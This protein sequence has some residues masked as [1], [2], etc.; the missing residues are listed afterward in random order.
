ML[1]IGIV[2]LRNAQQYIDALAE[3][4]AFSFKGIY[5]PC[6]LIDKNPKT[7][8]NVFQSFNDLCNQCNAV[9]FS[10]D[11]SLYHPLV[12]EAIRN[13]LDIFLSGVHNYNTSELQSLKLLHYEANT[14]I[15]VGHPFIY[16]TTFQEMKKACAQPLDIQCTITQ[17]NEQKIVSI[18][19][20]HVSS[21]LTL[22]NSSVHKASVNVYS[23]FSSMPDS[24][25]VR[26]DFNNG[27]IGNI[28]VDQY[29]F[30]K[31]H[32]IKMLGYN[33]MAEANL[34]SNKVRTINSL[35]AQNIIETNQP[36]DN[37]TKNELNNFY[38]NIMG[39]TSIHNTIDNEINT[40]FA[41]QKIHEKMRI[42]F[43]IF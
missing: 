19:R 22:I 25:R 24:M 30:E 4:P 31:T 35:D 17:T 16:T 29:G 42:N 27:T 3:L 20:S 11:D 1:N 40:H 7:Q 9:I 8:F 14:Y 6:L 39:N 10:I 12:S 32:T 13:S 38:N 28:C 26:L 21:L 36:F 34:I 37:I 33:V 18:V 23:S 41:C 2:G 15:Q 5:D 43:N